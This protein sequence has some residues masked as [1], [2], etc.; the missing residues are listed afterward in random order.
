MFIMRNESFICDNCKKNVSKHPDWSAR[1][2]C[3]YCL[4]SKHLDENF[5]WDRAS[6]CKAIMKAIWIENKKNKWI[7][8]KHKCEKCEKIILNKIAPDDNLLD[9][10]LE[11]N[12]NLI[13]RNI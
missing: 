13:W 10:T 6:N 5:P 3:P 12:N 9:L 7:M 11:L 2:H 4:C 8:L 1:N